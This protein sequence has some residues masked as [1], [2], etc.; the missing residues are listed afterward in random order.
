M[1]E[2]CYNYKNVKEHVTIFVFGVGGPENQNEDDDELKEENVY[3]R[4]VKGG[5]RS[6]RKVKY[7]IYIYMYIYM[8]ICKM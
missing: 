7:Y 1:G 8:Y 5:L 2:R 4:S 3:G 6:N